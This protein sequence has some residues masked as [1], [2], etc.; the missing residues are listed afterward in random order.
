MGVSLCLS[1]QHGNLLVGFRREGFFMLK[2]WNNA[3]SHLR[4]DFSCCL[5]THE[6][7]ADC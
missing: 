7:K 4:S 6:L 2:S 5:L 1:T 3:F